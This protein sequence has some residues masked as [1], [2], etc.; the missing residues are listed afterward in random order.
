M[1]GYQLV[2]TSA[3]GSGNGVLT[4]S[5]ACPSGKVALGGGMNTAY[6]D[7]H[8]VSSYPSA[9]G[10]WSV[11]VAAHSNNAAYNVTVFAICANG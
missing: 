10:T 1:T 6:T 4:A 7:L 8:M 9:A 11:K 3:A 5:A 2:S